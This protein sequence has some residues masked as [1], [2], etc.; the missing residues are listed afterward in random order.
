MKRI[1]YLLAIVGV[2]FVGCNPL[3]DIN[4]EIDA[5]NDPV[6]GSA[7]YTLT[8]EDYDDLDL[9]FGN[10]GSVE[11]A[12]IVLPDFISGL[13]PHFGNGSSVLIGYD[14]FIGN[15]EGLSDF[16]GA[17]TYQ[18]ENSDYALTGSDAF[19]FY[20]NV[21]PTDEIPTVLDVQIMSPTEGQ[22]VL[23]KYK[24]YFENPEIGLTNIYEATFPADYGN[25]ENI[26]LFGAQGWTEGASNVQGSGFA[27]GAMENEDW[28]VSPEID[29]AGQSG[30]LFQ[31]TQEID[32]LG[33]PDLIDIVVSTNF[34]TGGDVTAA[35]WT[36]LAFDKTIYGSMTTSEDF[37]FSAYDGEAIHVAFR[38]NSTD[39]DSPRW[40]VQSFAIKA[41]GISGDTDSKGEF[42]MYSGGSWEA[43]DG[44]YS[45]SASDY[46]SMGEE[47]GQPGRFD[48][49][50]SSTRAENYLP[51]FLDIKYPFAQEE[52]E[53]F[54]IYNYFSSNSGLGTRGNLYT[55]TNG[56]WVG[57]ENVIST[58]L[59]FGHDGTEWVPDNTIRYTFTSGD[60]S[61]ISDAF[62]TIY[63]GPAGNVGFFG[64]FDR[65][66][67][68]DNF[69]SDDMLLEAFNALLENGGFV[70]TEEQKYVLTY[71]IYNGATAE[72]S[73]SVIKTGGVWVYQ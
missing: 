5:Q 57:H 35:T 28:F 63:P 15:A 13:Y 34:T 30:L 42:F 60:V 41:V 8:D 72:E 16:T 33:D 37:D 22:I 50:S 73:M 9:N 32:F 56:E 36:V 39:S 18:F 4:N 1:I 52:D 69:W 24:Q 29:L 51:Q 40:R 10:F 26:D 45:L 3:E 61:F 59:Q 43:N 70:T 68:S 66:P 20:P 23:A 38:Y 31:I 64:S 53:I 7:E 58:T 21:D 14:L 71:I 67:S 47:S 55:F 19:G 11:E 49:F 44:V 46:D 17:D 6:V 54:I 2:I 65:R 27:G 12:K 62:S 48:N 25:F